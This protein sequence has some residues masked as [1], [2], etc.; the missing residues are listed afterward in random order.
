MKA[1]PHRILSG[2]FYSTHQS[3]SV[4]PPEYNT[5][6]PVTQTECDM[7][8]G[9]LGT[10]LQVIQPV[11]TLR[12]PSRRS[13]ERPE[14]PGMASCFVCI[15]CHLEERE[16]HKGLLATNEEDTSR[17][18]YARRSPCCI[19]VTTAAPLRRIV[20]TATRSKSAALKFPIG[21]LVYI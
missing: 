16:N 12:A 11:V 13:P 8:K 19:A 20:G 6:R 7:V 21:L 10:H 1:W 18:A 5:P 9:N 3:T 2:V 4:T 17:Q 15:G 14:R